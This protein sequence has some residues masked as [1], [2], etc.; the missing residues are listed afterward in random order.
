MQVYGAISKSSSRFPMP[1][2]SNIYIYCDL[3]IQ[4]EEELFEAIEDAKILHKRFNN[5][6]DL[7]I[8]VTRPTTVD[9]LRRIE[10]SIEGLENVNFDIDYH[11]LGIHKILKADKSK[12]DIGM[13]VLTKSLLNYKEAIKDIVSLKLPIFKVGKENIS[14]LKSTVLLL[15]NN[16]IY[17]QLSPL[18]F[19]ISN[20]LKI[21]PKVFSIDPMG[22]TKR[23]ELISH[24]NNLSKIFGQNVSIINEKANP[25]KRI[26]KEHNVLQI[27]PLKVEM[28]EKRT[29]KFLL[30][31]VIF[32]LLTWRALT[33]YWYL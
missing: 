9:V 21:K 24:L 3:F 22:D 14:S 18:L 27:L 11:N 26:Q 16:K 6:N 23:D 33:R 12:F 13:I 31:T 29:I 8:K 1:F 19:D 2:G 28:F 20:Q 30:Q 7:I 17:E 15:N 32:Y 4:S 25:I 10:K 5:D